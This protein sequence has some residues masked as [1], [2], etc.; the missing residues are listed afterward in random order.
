MTKVGCGF[1]GS[2][3]GVALGFFLRVELLF[4]REDFP[5]VRPCVAVLDEILLV[6]FFLVMIQKMQTIVRL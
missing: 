3:R 1:A 6:G 2:A 5:L 4:E